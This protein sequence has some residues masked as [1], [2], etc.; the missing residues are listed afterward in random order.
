[1]TEGAPDIVIGGFYCELKRKDHTKCK[2]QP[3]QV[4]YLQ[5]AQRCGYYACLA[6]GWEAAMEAFEEWISPAN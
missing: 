3:G 6:F 1:M 2:L 5:A 4:E